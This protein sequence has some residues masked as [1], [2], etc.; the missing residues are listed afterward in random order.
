MKKSELEKIMNSSI[1]GIIVEKYHI[2]EYLKY[3]NYYLNSIKTDELS[4]EDRKQIL[5]YVYDLIITLDDLV[6]ELEKDLQSNEI[7]IKDS[8]NE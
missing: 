8:P 6:N 5:S 4:K 1:Y 3:M 2:I 7:I